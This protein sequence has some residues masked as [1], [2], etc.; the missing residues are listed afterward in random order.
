MGFP[1]FRSSSS[2]KSLAGSRST[3]TSSF[4]SLNP[5]DLESHMERGRYGAFELTDAIRPSYDLQVIPRQ[6]YRHD[7]Y[8]DPES[9]VKIPVVLA[10]V[11]RERLF[12][13]FIDLVSCMG[14]V[15]N[16][17][18][19]SSHYGDEGNHRDFVRDRIEMP[20]LLSMLYEFE[21]LLMNDGCTGIAIVNRSRKQEIQF[22][23]HKLIVCYGSPMEIYERVLIKHDVYPDE[24]MRFLTEAE[25]V[26]S[27][28]DRFIESLESFQYRLG[29]D[30]GYHDDHHFET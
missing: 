1:G 3:P 12:E 6:G 25:H 24:S 2:K 29:L 20:I 19:E 16:L 18:L 15:V 9:K 13:L 28:S 5:D 10:S 21:D 17:V 14:D 22:D 30:N 26:H 7:E 23:E 8:I 11:S 27:S 4:A